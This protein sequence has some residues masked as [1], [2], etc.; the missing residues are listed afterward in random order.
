MMLRT[1]AVLIAMTVVLAVGAFTWTDALL[2]RILLLCCAAFP[3]LMALLCV[4]LLI[5]AHSRKDCNYF[6]YDRKRKANMLQ[7]EL[8]VEHISERLVQYM[9]L[10]RKGKELYL[11]SLFDEAGGAPEVFKPLFC[12]QILGMMSVC[13]E[14]LRWNNFVAGGKELADAFSTYLSQAGEGEMS[15]R[16]QYFIAQGMAGNT[17]E[18]RDYLREKSDYLAERMLEYTKAHIREFD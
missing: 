15:R 8:T 2:G 18:F 5:L 7:E 1:I 14:D 11:A 10:F 17:E 3:L 9:M 12:Y 4:Y 6:L 13:D 16:M